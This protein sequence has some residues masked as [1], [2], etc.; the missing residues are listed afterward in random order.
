MKKTPKT[1][2]GMRNTRPS[3]RSQHKYK[4]P[5]S[6]TMDMKLPTIFGHASFGDTRFIDSTD[7]GNVRTALCVGSAGSV[8]SVGSVAG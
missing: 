5:H 3:Q 8:S 1:H 6:N 4:M 2:S 7:V